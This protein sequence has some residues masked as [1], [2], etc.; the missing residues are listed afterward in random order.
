MLACRRVAK[1][2]SINGVPSFVYQFSM[3]LDNWIDYQALGNYHT[4][5]LS[6]VFD[7]QWPPILHDFN[8]KEKTLAA[9]FQS[10]WASMAEHGHPNGDLSADQ[11][12]WLAYVHQPSIS[13]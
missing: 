7:N 2:F 4:S 5:E 12:V 6:F 10:Y 13:L 9:S 8:A 1:Q 11:A 3:P